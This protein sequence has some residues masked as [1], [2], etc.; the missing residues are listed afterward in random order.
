MLVPT[1]PFSI[2]PNHDELELRSDIGSLTYNPNDEEGILY[3]SLEHRVD[4]FDL[5]D[6][7]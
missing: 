7:L 1:S 2:F 3:G 6:E 4:V 5:N